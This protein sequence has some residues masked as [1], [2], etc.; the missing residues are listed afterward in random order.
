M[1][2]PLSDLGLGYEPVAIAFLSEPPPGARKME[3][4]EAAS[5]GYWRRGSEGQSFYTTA[6]HHQNCPIGAFTNGVTLASDTARELESVV[7]M[8][9][10]PRI[11]SG[12]ECG[13]GSVSH[14]GLCRDI[15]G[16]AL[17]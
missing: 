9:V 7:G 16:R 11:D 5:C 3:R 2:Q 10:E 8:I 17:D 1:F 14:Q 13:A 12:S 6:E 15:R 4:T